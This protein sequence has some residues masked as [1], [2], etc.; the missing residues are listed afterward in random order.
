MEMTDT[1]QK[2]NT[3][4]A[5]PKREISTPVYKSQAT[6][7]LD[8]AVYLRRIFARVMLFVIIPAVV[9]VTL[10]YFLWATDATP[11]PETDQNYYD[12]AY[13]PVQKRKGADYEKVAAEAASFWDVEGNMRRFVDRYGLQDKRVLDV[14]SGR[15][16]L[17]DVVSDYAGLDISETVSSRYRKPFLVASATSMPFPDNSFDAPWSIWVLEHIPRPEAALREMRRVVKPGGLIFLAPP[18]MLHH[19]PRTVSTCDP[20]AISIGAGV[21]LK[22][23]YRFKTL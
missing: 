8:A 3:R 7:W 17:Q 1:H 15:G 18:G 6:L 14:G 9:L 22:R 21:W 16:Y 5:D 19:G 4:I 11:A 23:A 12:N 20:I 2:P 10:V 13:K